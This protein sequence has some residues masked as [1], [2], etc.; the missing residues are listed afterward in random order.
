M[1]SG[2]VHL[3][4]RH[5]VAANM[6]MAVL[7]LSG[8]YALTRLNVQFFPTFSLDVVT[9][10]VVWRGASAEDVEDGI[11]RPLEQRLKNVENLRNLSST[12]SLGLAN[13]SLEFEEGSDPVMALDQ[14][15]QRVSEFR[16]FP[17]EAEEPEISHATNYESIARVVIAGASREELRGLARRFERELLARGVDRVEIVGLPDEEISV[18]IPSRELER[19]DMTLDQVASRIAQVSQDASAGVLGDA[20]VGREVRG[21]EQR[22]KPD[23][24]RDLS[25]VSGNGEHMTLG[26][27]ADITRVPRT[28]S[29][30]VEMNGMPAVELQ[31]KRSESGNSLHAA[32]TLENW[33]ADTRPNLPPNIMIE[34]YDPQWQLIKERIDLLLKNGAS[35]L[36][37]VVLILYLFLNGRVA[38]WVAM[39]IPTA[40]LATL[41]VLLLIGGSINMISLFAL[42]MALGI[43]VDDAV[44]VGEDAYAHYRAGEDP[45]RASEGGARRM[46]A[47]VMSSSLTTIAAFL[48]L[49]LISG[50]IGKIMG[51]IPVVMVCVLIASL[52]E[53]FLILPAHLRQ[54][55]LH[56]RGE[57]SLR[58]RLEMGFDRFRDHVFR[59]LATRALDHRGVTLAAT[60][61]VMIAILGLLAGDRVKFTFFPSPESQVIQA[62]ATFVA[63]TPR[64]VTDAFAEHLASTLNETEREFGVKL[65]EHAVLY[66]GSTQGDGQPRREGDAFA[67][68]VV[69][70][71]RPDDRDVRNE[72]FIAAWEKRI[73]RPAGLDTL[74]VASRRTGPPGRDI[75]IRLTGEHAAS[76]KLAALKLQRTL[77][78]T[79]GVTALEDDMPYGREQWV[80]RI[81]PAG[82]ALGFTTEEL[83]RQLRA[84][85][86]GR[87]AQTYQDGPEEVEVRVRLPKAE[88]DHL[89][90]LEALT[91]RAPSGRFVP[92]ASVAEFH[93]RQG[94]EALRHADT[95]LA[96]EVM[97]NVD[98]RLANANQILAALEARVLPDLTREYS[99]RY[100]FEGRAADQAETAADM[101][102]GLLLGLA[103]IYIVLA[104][105][106]SSYGWPLVVMAAI[107]FGLAGALFGH[108]LMGLDLTVLS[109][110]GLFGLSGIVVNDSIVL[111]EFYRQQREAGM[112]V[113]EALIEAACL[114][115][116]A[117]LLT[118][119]TTI[120]GL[121]PLLFERSLQAQFLIPM[122]TSISFG[123]M[124]TTFL[125]LLA[126]P[127]LLSVHESVHAR[128]RALRGLPAGV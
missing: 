6:L 29:A 94:F 97:A 72:D 113:R 85:F 21:I 2:F 128:L 8:L 69:E 60:L 86:D 9:V 20:D 100:S 91:V 55:F 126:I 44:V 80:F 63:G 52:V 90:T 98:T 112:P 40:F 57:G 22:R 73:V 28:G 115:L 27:V 18:E 58:H 77:S 120:G 16:N 37:L 23:A 39:G 25:L 124:F 123:L 117:I 107:P 50:P 14:V 74:T 65:V 71:V 3:F 59:P 81:T 62:G 34:V 12:S 101:R 19:L 108:W 33:L 56:I 5:R 1:N 118:S 7:I 92:L 38:F 31:L 104:W 68:L 103:L 15:R 67:S 47:P 30:L 46:L 88:R 42:I 109:L 114:R 4:A 79:P 89:R 121:L 93:T 35:G 70:T 13:F 48:P 127:A 64:P 36:V 24:F 122:A 41:F 76:L 84:A 95:E 125:V 11:T 54:S 96:V 105:V 110:F 111:V 102:A 61:A 10:R 49:M 82:E 45:L 119:L 99:V 66:K 106:F 26:Q 83:G 116:R 53:C 43:I 32:R 78:D 75:A 17:E 51:A 87:L